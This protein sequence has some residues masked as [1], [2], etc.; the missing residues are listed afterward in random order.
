[1]RPRTSSRAPCAASSSHRAAVRR[2]C[3]TMARPYGVPVVRSHATTVSRWLVIPMAA[4]DSAPTC[5]TTSRSVERAASQISVASCSTQPGRGK[6]WAN[7]RYGR[8][9]R[10]A[11]GGH[12]PAADAGRAGVDGD[13]AAH[14]R[15]DLADRLGP[16]AVRRVG[17]GRAGG[18][19]PAPSVAASARRPGSAQLCQRLALVPELRQHVAEREVQR[20]ADEQPDQDRQQPVIPEEDGEHDRHDRGVDGPLLGQPAPRHRSFG[21]P[22]HGAD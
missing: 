2:S 18:P 10:C 4:T 7:S 12:R 13:H 20:T 8:H 3:H 19:D 15:F 14:R 21:V 11:V 17:A 16:V 6:C 5:S 22:S 9:A 1:M